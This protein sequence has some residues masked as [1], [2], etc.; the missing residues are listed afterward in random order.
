M[1]INHNLT[2]IRANFRF[3]RVNYQSDKSTRRLSHSSG[4]IAPTVSN[5][6]GGKADFLR[7]NLSECLKLQKVSGKEGYNSNA[8][9]RPPFQI[10]IVRDKLVQYLGPDEVLYQTSKKM[11]TVFS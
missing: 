9:M 4:N 2:A 7:I 1:I 10:T 11:N 5:P 8:F 6:K 3:K